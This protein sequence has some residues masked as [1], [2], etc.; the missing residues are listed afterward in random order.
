MPPLSE[1]ALHFSKMGKGDSDLQASKEIRGYRNIL[2]SS[3]LLP[4]FFFEENYIERLDR[5]QEQDGM[6]HVGDKDTMWAHPISGNGIQFMS[7]L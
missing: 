5:D 4:L 7:T 6:A 3:L 1:S 2:N